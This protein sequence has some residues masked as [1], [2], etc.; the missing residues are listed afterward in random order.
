[1]STCE[2]SACG[3]VTRPFQRS[4]SIGRGGFNL[5]QVDWLQV[6]LS[7][8]VIAGALATGGGLLAVTC[9]L[10]MLTR[11]AGAPPGGVT[12]LITVIPAPHP[13]PSPTSLITN[14][15]LA[16]GDVLPKGATVRIEGTGGD[17][18]RLR[19]KP[20]LQSAVVYVAHEGDTLQVQDGPQ[21]AEGFNWYLLATPQGETVS[22]WAAAD[23]LTIVQGP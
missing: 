12:A 22:G 7:P 21:P 10:L 8:R 6:L 5:H 4:R 20:G 14:A 18:L 17:G 9:L 13:Y 11:T 19:A 23:F 1:M 16:P 3:S 15:T 2:A